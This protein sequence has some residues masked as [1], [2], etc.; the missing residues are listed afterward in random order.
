MRGEDSLGLLILLGANAVR[1][2]EA[3]HVESRNRKLKLLTANINKI[4]MLHSQISTISEV[5]MSE[6]QS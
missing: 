4:A 2:G 1:K 5:T 3:G 6:L